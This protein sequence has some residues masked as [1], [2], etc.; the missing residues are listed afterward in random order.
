MT[1]FWATSGHLLLDREPGGGLRVTDDFLKA[2]LAR[3]EL[4]PPEEACAAERALHAKLMEAPQAQIAP[5][6][7]DAILDEDARANWLF[8]LGWRERLLAAPTLE[9]AYAGVIRDGV[10]DIPPLFLDQLVHV[11]LRAALDEVDDPY[12]VRAAECLFRPQRVTHHENTILLADADIIEGHEADRHASP[13]LAMLGGPAATSLD[14]LKASNADQYWQRSDGFDMVLDLG[15]T[16]SG[17]AALGQA[18][19]HWI[20]Q[21]HGFD[22]A[23]E[24][25]DK[26]K[27]ADWRWFV[28]LDA[29][30][31]AIGNALWTGESV[32]EEA[33][34]RVIALYTLTLPADVP[35]LPAARGKPIYLVMAMTPDRMLR[36][37][38]QNLVTGLPLALR[39]MAN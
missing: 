38:P 21:I 31:T 39:E 34:S 9:A 16:P 20:R 18:L 33:L 5:A 4:L 32:G 27:D 15:G 6:E 22:V 35:V 1:H 30:A 11:I 29:Q 23:I 14:I 24:P 37:K 3:P 36:L 28:G 13:L 12:V 2:Y 7:I 19:R 25:L 10:K 26:V 17:R 8:M